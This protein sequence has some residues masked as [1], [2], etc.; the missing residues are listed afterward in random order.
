MELFDMSRIDAT[1]EALMQFRTQGV[2]LSNFTMPEGSYCG[3]KGWLVERPK[4]REGLRVS[5][6]AFAQVWG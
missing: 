6:L 4:R 1:L 3:K 2:D 5:C